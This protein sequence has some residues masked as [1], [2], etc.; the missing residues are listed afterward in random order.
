MGSNARV[1]ARNSVK[2]WLNRLKED[3][4]QRKKTISKKR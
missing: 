1:P 3:G 2:E 4:I